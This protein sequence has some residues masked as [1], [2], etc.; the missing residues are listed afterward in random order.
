MANTETPCLYLAFA[1]A[2]AAAAMALTWAPRPKLPCFRLSDAEPYGTIGIRLSVK[3]SG[4]TSMIGSSLG[5]GIKS[6][7]RSWLPK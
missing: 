3:S 5:S 7:S 2:P 6:P 4:G 1:E